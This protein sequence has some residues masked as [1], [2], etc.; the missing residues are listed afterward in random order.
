MQ[1]VELR[2][3]IQQWFESQVDIKSWTL[4]YPVELFYT[5]DN[6]RYPNNTGLLSTIRDIDYDAD[7]VTLYKFYLPFAVTFRFSER[8]PLHNL[9][10]GVLEG[11]YFNVIS[12]WRK[13]GRNIDE[14]VERTFIKERIE[15]PILI[16]QAQDATDDWLVS[17]LFELGVQAFIDFS[18]PSSILPRTDCSDPVADKLYQF[19]N[20]ELNTYNDAPVLD[21]TDAVQDYGVELD[22]S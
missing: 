9:P 21:K 6:Q 20:I 15:N 18:C 5:I 4:N 17:L 11:L 14:D 12:L 2:N 3:K 19:T 10:L 1:I 8:V 7:Q 22:F 13:R 16:Q